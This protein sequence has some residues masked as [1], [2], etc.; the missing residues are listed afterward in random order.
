LARITEILDP[1][2][3]VSAYVLATPESNPLARL[4]GLA[5]RWFDRS[6]AQPRVSV[7]IDEFEDADTRVASLREDAAGD[8]DHEQGSVTEVASAG[9]DEYVFVRHYVNA[10]TAIVG[11]CQ[12]SL[13]APHD[14]HDLATLAEPALEI[15]RIVGCSAYRNDFVPPSH[16]DEWPKA[17]WGFAPD[18]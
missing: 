18:H 12:I 16:T 11:D 14:F 3:H 1:Y 17:N 4:N 9:R 6:T 8:G 7:F 15:G 13:N 10:L 5:C 2:L